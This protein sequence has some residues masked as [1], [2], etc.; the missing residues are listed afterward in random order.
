MRRVRT[1]GLE[2][3]VASGAGP[4]RREHVQPAQRASSRHRGQWP[5]EGLHGESSRPG[6]EHAQP[7][8]RAARAEGGGGSAWVLANGRTEK[9]SR[10]RSSTGEEPKF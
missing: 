1:A 6:V 5:R 4:G 9:R 8:W 3:N 2:G 7:E 10:G